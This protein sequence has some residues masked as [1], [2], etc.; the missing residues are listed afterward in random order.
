MSETIGKTLADEWRMAQFIGAR[1]SLDTSDERMMLSLLLQRSRKEKPLDIEGLEKRF[2]ISRKALLAKVILRARRLLIRFR[3]FIPYILDSLTKKDQQIINM[4]Y[5]LDGN[6]WTSPGKVCKT[7]GITKKDI[8]RV[9]HKALK[10]I[11]HGFELFKE[12]YL[13]D[14]EKK[15]SKSVSP[16]ETGGI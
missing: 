4:L 3:D 12:E 9:E 15:K 6:D 1:N 8:D 10:R 7:F 16:T 14:Q 2:G 13:A 11:L 5:G